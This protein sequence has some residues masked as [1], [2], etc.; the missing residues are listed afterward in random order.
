M[1]S[2]LDPS[3]LLSLFYLNQTQIPLLPLILL[4]NFYIKLRQV[5]DAVLRVIFHKN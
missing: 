4:S 3:A 1:E 2:N 5:A